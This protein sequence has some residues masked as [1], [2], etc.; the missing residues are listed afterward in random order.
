M[1][2]QQALTHDFPSYQI[3]KAFVSQHQTKEL[4]NT[5][6]YKFTSV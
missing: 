2:A 5:I 6:I 4:I 3:F 1:Y